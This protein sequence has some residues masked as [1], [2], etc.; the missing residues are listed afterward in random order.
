MTWLQPTPST[1]EFLAPCGELV[2]PVPNGADFGVTDVQL[3]LEGAPPRFWAMRADHREPVV[4]SLAR[5][6]H[7]S[8][9][10]ASAD[11]KPWWM[12]L[13]PPQPELAPPDPALIQLFRIEPGVIL[14]LHAGT[15]HSGPYFPDPQAGFFL[16]ELQNTNSHDLTEVALP[17]PFRLALT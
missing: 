3:T 8:Q 7:C 13:A 15:W 17:Q 9:C 12:V 16:L 2:L 14:K 5:H 1:P 6:R 11:G 4:A 10:L